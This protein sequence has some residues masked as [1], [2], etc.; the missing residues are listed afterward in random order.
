[1]FTTDRIFI[2]MARSEGNTVALFM[3]ISSFTDCL[4]LYYRY[5]SFHFQKLGIIP[6]ECI[7]TTFASYPPQKRISHQGPYS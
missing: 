5:S 7:W 1:M 2:A 3:L 4:V 6:E